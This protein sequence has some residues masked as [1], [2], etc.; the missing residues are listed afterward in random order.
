M[1]TATGCGACGG[2]GYSATQ[3]DQSDITISDREETEVLWGETFYT[4]RQ[5]VW[6]LSDYVT[7]FGVSVGV[8]PG[9]CDSTGHTQVNFLINP[10]VSGAASL[11]LRVKV[12][13]AGGSYFYKDVPV[14]VGAWQRVAVNL[15][16]M[17]LGWA[18]SPTPCR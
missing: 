16:D 12:K 4:Q 13:D 6:E 17:T 18:S 7:A 3:Q 5:V 10:V 2:P 15:A 14:Q 1:T 8:D 9:R 11:T